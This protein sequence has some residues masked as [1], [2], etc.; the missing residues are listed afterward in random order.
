MSYD[1]D[2]WFIHKRKLREKRFIKGSSFGRPS[3]AVLVV[4]DALLGSEIGPNGQQRW[5]GAI[6]W[7]WER[8]KRLFKR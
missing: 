1:F 2:R 4:M 3:K 7:I 8:M 5:K 6:P